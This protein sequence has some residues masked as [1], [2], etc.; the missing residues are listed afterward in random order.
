MMMTMMA[1]AQIMTQ[2]VARFLRYAELLV[3]DVFAD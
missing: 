1:G 3:V 2:S